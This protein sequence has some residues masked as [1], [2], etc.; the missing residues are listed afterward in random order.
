MFEAQGTLDRDFSKAPKWGNDDDVYAG[1]DCDQHRRQSKNSNASTSNQLQVSQSRGGGPKI[2][3]KLPVKK[4]GKKQQEAES[5]DDVEDDGEG[6]SEEE[7]EE[8]KVSLKSR[9]AR[10]IPLRKT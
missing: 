9:R 8:E 10:A 3:P 5:E 6:D 4:G 7:S 2:K 1:F